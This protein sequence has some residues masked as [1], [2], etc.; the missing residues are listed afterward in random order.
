M[1]LNSENMPLNSNRVS[2]DKELWWVGGLT[3]NGRPVVRGYSYSYHD[4]E[5][6]AQKL[7][8]VAGIRYARPFRCDS[9]QTNVANSVWRDM[10]VEDSDLGADNILQRVKHV[11]KEVDDEDL[12]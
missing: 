1:D 9:V 12:G 10:L 11:V 5:I 7:M 6:K 8:S 3:E 2:G 4:A